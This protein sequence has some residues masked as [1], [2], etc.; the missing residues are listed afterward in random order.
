MVLAEINCFALPTLLVQ[1][2]KHHNF[3]V[4]IVI[5]QKYLCTFYLKI[6]LHKY[7]IVCCGGV[8]LLDRQFVLRG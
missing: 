2:I 1:P 5:K 8:M 6:I 3:M 4:V 7:L